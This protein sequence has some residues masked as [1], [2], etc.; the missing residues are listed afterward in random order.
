MVRFVKRKNK[1]KENSLENSPVTIGVIGTDYKIGTTSFAFLMA[2][3]LCEIRGHKV[4]MV[5]IKESDTSG[6]YSKISLSVSEDRKYEKYYM[7]GNIACFLN[8]DDALMYGEKYDYIIIDYGKISNSILKDYLRNIH[9]IVVT[10]CQLWHAP[11]NDKAFNILENIKESKNWLYVVQGTD[12]DIGLLSKTR[13]L[14]AVKMP[15]IENS[16]KITNISLEFFNKI[17]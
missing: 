1:I 16:M 2:T 17:I 10:S 15:Y 7:I 9:K 11:S 13:N 3:F 14:F 12:K 8:I 5:M 4:A 6:V